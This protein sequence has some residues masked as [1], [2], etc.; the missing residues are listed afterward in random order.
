MNSVVIQKVVLS[1][2]FTAALELA[3]VRMIGDSLT[4]ENGVLSFMISAAPEEA[5]RFAKPV[6]IQL[7]I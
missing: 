2:L 6:K 7:G 3:V 5:G 1:F 4:Q